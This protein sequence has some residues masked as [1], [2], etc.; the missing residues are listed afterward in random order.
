MMRKRNLKL[1]KI[2][3]SLT[4]VV[5][6]LLSAVSFAVNIPSKAMADD[7]TQTLN[8]T[9]EKTTFEEGEAIFVTPTVNTVGGKDWVGI[10]PIT[11]QNKAIYWRYV[12]EITSDP[13]SCGLGSGVKFDLRLAFYG[14]DTVSSYKNL[15]AGVY[16]IIFVTSNGSASTASQGLVITIVPSAKSTAHMSVTKTHFYEGESIMLTPTVTTAGAKDWVGISVG[17]DLDYKSTGSIKWSYIDASD[18]NAAK[19][20]AGSGVT[21]DV[22]DFYQP[23][24]EGIAKYRALQAGTYTLLYV[25]N[26]G[27]AY[28]A[29]ETIEITIHPNTKTKHLSIGKSTYFAGEPIMVTPTVDTAKNNDWIGITKDYSISSIRWIYVDVAPYEEGDPRNG[30]GNNVAVDIRKGSVVKND[31]NKQIP[32]GEYQIVFGKNDS[33]CNS[34]TECLTITVVPAVPPKPF[35]ASLTLDN[36]KDGLFEGTMT[37]KCSD[38]DKYNDYQKPAHIAMKW[39]D[40]NG[41]PLSGYSEL[42]RRKVTSANMTFKT[43]DNVIIPANAEKLLIYFVNE[44]GEYSESTVITLPSGSQYKNTSKLV[45]EFNIIS[46]VHI[47]AEATQPMNRH[48]QLLLKDIAQ[49]MP[50]SSGIFVNGDIVDYGEQALY[51]FLVD[52]YKEAKAT[53]P[54]LP[55][56]YAAM[57]NH[58]LFLGDDHKYTSDYQ[59]KLQLW[60]SN[61]AKI[62]GGF[63]L[64]DNVPYYD[65]WVNGIH[66]IFLGSESSVDGRGHL[67]D[68]Q[69]TW[70]ETKLNENR[71]GNP[72]FLF[73]HQGLSDTVAGTMKSQGWHG[74]CA[75]DEYLN[76]NDHSS[77]G[78]A[79]RE[80]KLRDLVY[81]YPEIQMFA[82]HSHWY[83]NAQTNILDVENGPTFVNTASSG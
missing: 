14:G 75:G 6:F 67:S 7:S 65:M 24:A 51:T 20:G 71:T 61:V 57:G 40:A 70:L 13:R 81:K 39:A 76:S 80:K 26:N 53:Y 11:A 42:A 43:Y 28:S 31:V 34:I 56:L 30:S 23:D 1:S 22:L 41:K 54:N 38:Y 78:L 82:G 21:V 73:L 29:T 72:I 55:N 63:D 45:N 35:Y 44:G 16:S 36:A 33:P 60:L 62:N 50:N 37:V 12:D 64:P 58:E 59:S 47:K 8:M 79:Q 52:K 83:F 49:N 5:C 46:D 17:G 66:Y 32:A 4:C 18:S 77:S 9:I 25:P 69:L 19:A 15:P 10:V 3:L 2:I 48:Y 27:Y 68:K 74:V